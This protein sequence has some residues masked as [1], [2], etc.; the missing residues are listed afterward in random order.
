MNDY[1][2]PENIPE[3]QPQTVPEVPPLPSISVA[4]YPSRIP[5]KL[6]AQ[7]RVELGG[8][9]VVNNIRVMEGKNGP[10]VSM[11]RTRGSDGEFHDI[12]YPTR[13]DLRK[14]LNS[15]VLGEF[16]RLTERSSVREALR[17]AAQEPLAH[18]PPSMERPRDG[19]AR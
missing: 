5:G 18:Q 7:A 1:N 4:V 10:F 17:E 9:F 13:G 2:I 19:E 16:Q 3:S 11:P 15:A 14:A 8:V 12:C 6:L